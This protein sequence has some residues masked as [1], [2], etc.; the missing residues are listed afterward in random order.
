[1]LLYVLKE[2][3]EQTVNSVV[4]HVFRKIAYVLYSVGLNLS[5][6]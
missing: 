1:M 2:A 3:G 6:S 5:K 4:K